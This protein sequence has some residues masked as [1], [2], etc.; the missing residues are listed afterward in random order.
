MLKSSFTLKMQT[1]VA[2]G[3]S[4]HYR[5]V[6]FVA[7]VGTLASLFWARKLTLESDMVAL[8]PQDSASVKEL[9]R[10]TDK[11]GGTGDLQIMIRSSAPE[12]SL[13][14][15][16]ELLPEIRALDWVEQAN[17]G[18]DT[19]FF[20]ARKLLYTDLED[21]Q[22]IE[23][24]IAERI[25][26]ENLLANPFYIDLEEEPPPSLDF[27]DIEERYRLEGPRS[28]YFRN[29]SGTILLILVQPSGIASDL[30]HAQQV[31]RELQ[32]LI[33]TH[34]PAEFHPSMKVELGG[35]Y[36]NRIDEYTA[37]TQDV[38]SSS[39]VVVIAILLVI[40]W[41]FGSPWASLVIMVPL[42]MSLCWTFALG[43]L[44]IGSL[45][46]VTVFLIVVLMGLGIDFGIQMLAGF[47][48]E[49]ASGKHL[50][51]A[52]AATLHTAGR[53]SL[54]ATL[55]TAACFLTLLATEFRGF[56]EF[57]IIASIGLLASALSYST[58][59]PAL[60][61]WLSH[62][63]R[64]LPRMPKVPQFAAAQPGRKTARI[65]LAVS[66]ITVIALV[67]VG[68]NAQFEY[69]LR[70]LRADIPET[71]E[72]N[73][74]VREVFPQARDPAA[75]LVEDPDQV[76]E[77][78]AEIEQ[79]RLATAPDS[80]IESVLSVYDLIPQN[81]DEKLAILKR[82]KESVDELSDVLTEEEQEEFAE[83]REDLDVQPVEGIAELP[84][85]ILRRFFGRPGTPGQ[86]I[87][88]YQDESLMD[89]REARDF[90]EAF[91]GLEVAGTVYRAVSEPLIYV[92]MLDALA[93]DTPRALLL[94]ALA[95]IL[96]LFLDFHSVR[97]VAIVLVPLIT[98]LAVMVGTMAMVPIRLNFLNAIVLPSMLGLSVDGGVH[99]YHR[100][101]ERG[102]SELGH[103]MR[104]TGSAV[105]IC[106]FT[107]LL[108]FAGMLLA[109]HPGLRSIGLLALIG[110]LGGLFG[111]LV[112][113]PALVVSFSSGDDD[114]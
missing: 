103:I 29:E 68:R 28:P 91:K 101:Q 73:Q 8:L 77:V 18:T 64:M 11:L 63:D 55:T 21:L 5:L 60:L 41:Y 25:R 53:S 74:R 78:E 82:V 96:L 83:F 39:L 88:V 89:L 107:S 93:R 45:N 37:I 76:L 75:V 3:I 71:R 81:Q 104:G 32:E 17:M 62:K 105:A 98:G 52:L 56:V 109:D 54:V 80:P 38:K 10:L 99:L 102:I 92:A 30:A 9:Q 34:D 94:S 79:R 19:S 44:L 43:Y 12:K 33:D 13:E 26:Y 31:Q 69:D 72:F 46:L 24:R 67:V 47:Q 6:I 51:H 111:A 50:N 14:F 113:L 70:A 87:Y 66:A 4:K 108:G 35:A 23:E 65:I 42:L 61:S 57:G 114:D 106:T 112:I 16:R 58:V 84:D 85:E 2:S 15:A 22:T 86:V 40:A 20:E 36:R 100:I 110:L 1:R 49:R 27:S 97:S 59:L 48:S 7:L 95:L 90:S